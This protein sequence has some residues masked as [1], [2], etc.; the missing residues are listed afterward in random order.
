MKNTLISAAIGATLLV[1][2]IANAY[3][4]GDVIV[5]AGVASVQPNDSVTGTLKT[6]NA[7]VKSDTQLGLTATYM[8]S[9]KFGVELLAATPFKHKITANGSEI[10]ETKQ[11]PPT[12]SLQYY[13]MDAGSAYQPYVGVGLNYTAFFEEKSSLGELKLDNSWGASIQAGID[14]QINDHMLLNTAVWYIDIDTD[15]KLNSANIGTVSVDPWVYM[16][17]IG[18][19]F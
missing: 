5:R 6:L 7:G 10:G 9:D 14:Y 3:Q 1:S 17:G 13:P 18:Y 4:N 12:L 11:L 2:P 8:F 15:A 16:V 19:K